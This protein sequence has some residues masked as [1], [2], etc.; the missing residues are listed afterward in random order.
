MATAARTVICRTAVAWQAGALSQAVQLSQSVTVTAS[1]WRGGCS[2][3]ACQSVDWSCNAI[4]PTVKTVFK[5]CR[6]TSK[7]CCL[8]VRPVFSDSVVLSVCSSIQARNMASDNAGVVNMFLSC[9]IMFVR[10]SLFL[11][12]LSAFMWYKVGRLFGE[13]LVIHLNTLLSN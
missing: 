7:K 5:W 13:Y 4:Q 6:T 1:R 3:S 12:I 11:Y 10:A 2:C 8:S 9:L